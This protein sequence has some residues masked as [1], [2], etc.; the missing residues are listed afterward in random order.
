MNA[1]AEKVDI[2]QW[3]AGL[4]D[5]S[6]LKQLKQIKEQSETRKREMFHSIS[7]EEHESILRGLEDSVNGRVLSHSDVRKRYE[8][9]L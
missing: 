8:K 9:W 3:V 7:K 1:Y 2:I 5:K 6:T 4:E